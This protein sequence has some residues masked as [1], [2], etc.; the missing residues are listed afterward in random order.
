[1][2]HKRFKNIC[3]IL[4]FGLVILTGCRSEEVADTGVNEIQKTLV[5]KA[6]NGEGS[7]SLGKCNR[8]AKYQLAFDT[9]KWLAWTGI[10]DTDLYD[11]KFVRL[12]T[13]EK[14]YAKFYGNAESQPDRSH[15]SLEYTFKKYFL[16][17]DDE[18]LASTEQIIN[19]MSF[20]LFEKHNQK[21][22]RYV[23]R[24]DTYGAYGHGRIVCVSRGKDFSDYE[25][26]IQELLN[27]FSFYQG[28]IEDKSKIRGFLRSITDTADHLKYKDWSG[29]DLECKWLD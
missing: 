28:K 20:H 15:Q 17:D 5:W 18:L 6:K 10:S 22:D 3:S 11:M 21:T 9:S 19:D 14:F 1:M 26:D 23:R 7:Y 8:D 12:G 13:A 24:Y 2:S 29:E 25:S 27:G 4:S 16:N